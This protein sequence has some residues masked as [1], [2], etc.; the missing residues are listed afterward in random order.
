MLSMYVV[1]VNKMLVN[2]CFLLSDELLRI[3]SNLLLV[4]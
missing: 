3:A 4:L 1:L 2:K